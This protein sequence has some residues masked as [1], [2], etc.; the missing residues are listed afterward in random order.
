VF[1][2]YSQ[3]KNDINCTSSNS[4]L[5]KIL[6]VPLDVLIIYSREIIEKKLKFK[7][8]NKF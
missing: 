1:N 3:L 7:F 8:Q 2:P 5:L 4:E 6:F